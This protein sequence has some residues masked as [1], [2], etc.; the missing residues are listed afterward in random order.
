[1]KTAETKRYL[2]GKQTKKKIFDV[3]KELI[4][5]KGYNQVTV[6]E[7]CEKCGLSK[8]AFYIHYKSKEAIV[9]QLYRDDINEYINDQFKKYADE[10]PGAAPVD[11][12][13]AFV[14]IALSFSSV[15]GA[16]LTKLAHIVIL[17]STSP[18]GSSYLADCLKPELLYEI[19]DEGLAR[20]LFTG[21][22]S[23]EE[24]AN[25]LYTYITGALITW[26]QS[27]FAYDIVKMEE[28]SVEVLVKGLQ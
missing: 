13:K 2:K 18:N 4:L 5:A 28:K 19:V 26:C 25:Y 3:A 16:E 1:M 20:A 11:K 12:L 8:G 6:D 15:A 22:L 24:I 21:E 14:F 7:I 17:S 23:R 27:D 10:H 9:K